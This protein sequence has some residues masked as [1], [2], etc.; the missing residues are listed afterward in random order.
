MAALARHTAPP[1]A[2]ATEPAARGRN[3]ADRSLRRSRLHGLTRPTPG[4]SASASLALSAVA[5]RPWLARS[6]SS[7]CFRTQGVVPRPG[8]GS[9]DQPQHERS[10]R[11]R[12]Q[13]PILALPRT[14]R[15][16]PTVLL[17]HCSHRSHGERPGR[18]IAAA[19]GPRH[20]SSRPWQLAAHQTTS[21]Q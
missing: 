15:I 6:I 12:G 2:E 14:C 20:G 5:R 19:I 9:S 16:K 8:A 7:H 17:P 3:I 13:R 1:T 21:K 4:A 18:N 10:H 11:H